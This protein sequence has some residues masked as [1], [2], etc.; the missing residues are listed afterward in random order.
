MAGV[1]KKALINM[2]THMHARMAFSK[3]QTDVKTF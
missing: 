2:H 3:L 1:E